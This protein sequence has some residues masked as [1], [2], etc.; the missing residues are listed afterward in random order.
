MATPS[1]TAQYQ[2][3][4]ALVRTFDGEESIEFE[5]SEK[6]ARR[7][8]C[9]T[10]LA[11]EVPTVLFRDLDHSTYS[12]GVVYESKHIEI[13]GAFKHN[14]SSNALDK[15]KELEFK[16]INGK[17]RINC[18][19]QIHTNYKTAEGI[20]QKMLRRRAKYPDVDRIMH[21]EILARAKEEAII[22]K[23]HIAG[24]LMNKSMLVGTHPLLS[25]IE[26]SIRYL[27]GKNLF[28]YDSYKAE[29]REISIP[30]AL[31]II[32]GNAREVNDKC[33]LTN[34]TEVCKMITH[35]AKL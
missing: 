11:P 22:T 13:K 17:E 8:S 4:G 12:L 16:E 27:P 31:G 29:L 23:E 1:V 2:K 25:L 3:E 5:V 20:R 9:M 33:L 24:L 26:H 35:K 15:T 30:F 7:L 34:V 19:G 14:I 6:N 18:D 32:M 21:N 28:Y 10:Y